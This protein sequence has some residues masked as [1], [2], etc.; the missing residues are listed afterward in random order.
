MTD[1]PFDAYDAAIEFT[2]VQ[3][4]EKVPVHMTLTNA[5]ALFAATVDTAEENGTALYDSPSAA[6]T[7]S[8]SSPSS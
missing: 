2:A 7:A 5:D 6:P 3:G 8:S 1:Y 4:G